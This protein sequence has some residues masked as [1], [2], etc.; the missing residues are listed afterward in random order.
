METSSI[1]TLSL[2]Y[3]TD[4]PQMVLGE[5]GRLVQTMVEFTLT[6]EDRAKRTDSAAHIVDTVGRLN[7]TLRGQTDF[8]RKVWDHLHVISGFQLDVD[9]PFPAPQRESRSHRYY[10]VILQ[11]LINTVAE[12]EPSEERQ[13]IEYDIANQMKRA[14]LSWNK[15][16]VDDAVIFNDLRILSAGRLGQEGSALSVAKGVVSQNAPLHTKNRKKKKPNTTNFNNKR[17]GGFFR[18]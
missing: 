7:P 11:N 12:M 16:T 15:D 13:G 2:D 1:T 14:Y 5:Y 9:G 4:R 3:N 17:K 6:I 8:A 18:K 10:G